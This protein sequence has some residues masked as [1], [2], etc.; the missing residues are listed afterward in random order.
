[1][2]TYGF[3]TSQL[4]GM[5]ALN[6]YNPDNSID[7]NTYSQYNPHAPFMGASVNPVNC[8]D[9]RP[10]ANYPNWL[11]TPN[12]QVDLRQVFLNCDKN[13]GIFTS[14]VAWPTD[15]YTATVSPI[16]NRQVC[17]TTEALFYAQSGYFA[18]VVIVQWSNIF[19]CKSRKVFHL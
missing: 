9:Y 19:A 12:D 15:C 14:A 8:N 2:N 18:T 1:M 4:I 10:V 16:S 17:F 11:S 3:P 6:A 5:L 13:S 7:W